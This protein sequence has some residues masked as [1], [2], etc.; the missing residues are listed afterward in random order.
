MSPSRTNGSSF[1]APGASAFVSAFSVPSSCAVFGTMLSSPD[2]RG[3]AG[4]PADRSGHRPPAAA[5]AR[6]QRR[7]RDRR[8]GGRAL[9]PLRAPSLAGL[10]PGAVDAL[11]EAGFA[12]G[13]GA[14]FGA[15]LVFDGLR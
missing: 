5:V 3:A 12:P 9:L 2:G 13:R 7:L 14:P 10:L 4:D 15:P 1:A 6:G 11:L 8:A